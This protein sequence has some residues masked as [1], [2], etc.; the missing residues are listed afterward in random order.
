[1]LQK[2]SRKCL[3]EERTKTSTMTSH[4]GSTGNNNPIVCHSVQ[5]SAVESVQ[6]SSSSMYLKR[7][8]L[9]Q[10]HIA[11]ILCIR[12]T[13][14]CGNLQSQGAQNSLRAL[15]NPFARF[16]WWHRTLRA[17][18]L[19]FLRALGRLLLRCWSNA[20]ETVSGSRGAAQAFRPARRAEPASAV[21]R[22][23]E[24]ARCRRRGPGSP[25]RG[26]SAASSSLCHP[27]GK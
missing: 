13:R 2:I 22:R 7:S 9:V 20:A 16:L 15:L 12:A 6:F 3:I 10:R 27:K 18:F 24:R 23:L 1:M 17:E 5:S 26:A 8:I 11:T 14:V 4:H 21:A 19:F 25:R